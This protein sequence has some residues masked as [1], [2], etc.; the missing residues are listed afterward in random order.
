MTSV[1][2][3][4]REAVRVQ[5]LVGDDVVVD[6]LLLEPVEEMGVGVVLVE[7]PSRGRRARNGI[8]P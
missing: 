2:L 7:R 3:D 6:A 4:E 1:S 8:A 5:V